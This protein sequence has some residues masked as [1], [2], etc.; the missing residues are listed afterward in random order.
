MTIV[1][2]Y[3]LSD[4]DWALIGPLLPRQGRGGRWNDHRTVMNGMFWVLRSGSAWRDMPER[5][6]KRQ[7][8]Y[9]RFVRWRRDGTL[10]RIAG[11]LRERLH[12]EGRIE[13]EMWCVDGTS[14]RA[15]KA[16]AGARGAR[17]ARQKKTGPSR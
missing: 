8:I 16:A 17:G 12:G 15:A 2:R 13:W 1:R 9:D 6:G 5:Y 3:E 14:I 4:G 11:V 7:T 10:D